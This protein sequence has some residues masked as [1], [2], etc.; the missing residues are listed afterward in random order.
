MSSPSPPPSAPAAPGGGA[1]VWPAFAAYL[2][3]FVTIVV[4]S[5]F[6]VAAVTAM[7]PEVPPEAL[8]RSLP[9]L[10]AGATASSAALL[11]TLAVA[12]RGTSAR[13]LRLVPGRERGRDLLVMML[14]LLALGQA[15]DSLAILL[16]LGREGALWEARQALAGAAGEQLFAAVVIIGPLAGTAEELFFRGFMQ[17]RLRARWSPPV[18]VALT[19]ACFAL[20]HIEWLHALMAFV[21]GLYLGHITERAGSALPAAAGHV[22]NNAAF[23]VLAALNW[24]TSAPGPNAVLL[25]ASLL[26]TAACLLILSRTLRHG[27][28]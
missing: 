21:L 23:T 9:G 19:S 26:V 15:L 4:F 18:A 27:A 1:A 20:L 16:G 10:L 25:A 17:T 22:V 28:G 2:T 8:L 6:A 24:T 3:A 14:G 11:L 7:Y 12:G 13:D 5:M